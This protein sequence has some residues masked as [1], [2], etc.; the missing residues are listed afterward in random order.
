MKPLQCTY[1]GKC[2]TN[3]IIIYMELKRQIHNFHLITSLHLQRILHE[4][5]YSVR[6]NNPCTRNLITLGER[7]CYVF[8]KGNIEY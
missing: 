6:S 7:E 2:T 5:P 8:N 4:Q 1:P 3:V